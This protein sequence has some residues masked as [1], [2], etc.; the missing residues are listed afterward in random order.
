VTRPSHAPLS[1]LLVE[2]DPAYVRVARE[3]LAASRSEA[4]SLEHVGALQAALDLLSTGAFDA[5][6]LALPLPD[7]EGLEGL[8]CVLARFPALPVVVLV[9]W[10]DEALGLEALQQGA[11]DYIVKQEEERRLAKALRFAVERKRALDTLRQLDKA[12][13]TTQL[14]I[15]VTDPSGRIVYVNRAEAEMHGYQ[16]GEMLG[17]DA[18]SLSPRSEW[19]AL[20]PEELSSLHT[21][22]RERV[23]SRKDGSTFPVQLMSDVVKDDAGRPLGVVTTC[24]DISER[25]RAEQ[26]LR[27]SEERYALAVRGANDGI[28]DWSLGDDHIYFSPRWKRMLGYAE[29]E[30]SASP[31][32]WLTRVHPE[33]VA[34]VRAKLA[35]HAEGASRHF[36]DEHRIRH[37]NG[38]YL[39]VLTRGFALRGPD[40]RA[41]RMAGA[42]TDVTDRRAHDPLTGLPNRALTT[43][44]LEQALTRYQRRHEETFAV[45]FVDLDNFKAVNDTLGHAAGDALLMEVARRLEGSL[46]PGDVVGRLAGDEFGVLLE[47]AQDVDEAVQVAERLQQALRQPL[48]WDGYPMRLS[49]SIGIA[50]SSTGYESAE[51][52]LREADAAMYRAKAKGRDRFEIFDAAMR[53]R[54]RARQRL[55]EGLSNALR[56]DELVLF[57]QPMVALD[58]ARLLGME[59]LLRWEHPEGRLLSPPEV[60][61]LAEQTGQLPR[62]EDWT[63]REACR[64]AGR[65]RERMGAPLP[66]A[67]NVSVHQFRNAV[68]ADELLATVQEEGLSPADLW[69]DITAPCLA[70]SDVPT[71]LVEQLRRAGVRLFLDDFGADETPLAPLARCPLDAVKLDPAL[72]RELLD[73]DEPPLLL[74]ALAVT[75]SL[76]LPVLAEG[77]ETAEQRDKLLQLGC[78]LGQGAFFQA[79]LSPDD[80]LALIVSRMTPSGGSGKALDFPAPPARA[81]GARRGP[82]RKLEPARPA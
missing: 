60:L 44:R 11:Q 46:R 65:W 80:A 34:R 32:E 21:W 7:A 27:E 4:W 74:A 5:L 70:D 6:L 56:N 52:I 69:L 15:S 3:T 22:K 43:E 23:R 73:N 20:T 61:A 38:R 10:N 78:A 28:W 37:R 41:T 9:G 55:V 14:G 40:G 81:S 64:Q 45:L 48:S 30:L 24:E 53:E 25:L 1:I 59:A 62:I 13:E 82:K 79:P 19:R 8:R 36:E 50:L 26:A 76:G 72:V 68:F 42:Q 67:V 63:L 16:P 39:W 33:D 77:V 47:R 66:V 71:A 51:Q 58:D 18:R 31:E 2:P 57:F 17:L 75:R 54:L 35:A 29:D 12:M 49:A